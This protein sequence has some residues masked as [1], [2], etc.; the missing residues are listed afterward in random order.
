VTSLASVAQWTRHLIT[1]QAIGGS[2]PSRRTRMAG[3]AALLVVLC[4]GCNPDAASTHTTDL[5]AYRATHGIPPVVRV[6]QLDAK[7][8]ARAQIMAREGSI[9]HSSSAQ[10]TYGLPR[11][12]VQVAENIA[13]VGTIGRAIPALAGSPAHQAIMADPAYTQVGIGVVESGGRVFV[14]QVFV[15]R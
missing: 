15:A 8:V 12:W 14:A 9:S 1:D 6:R 2:S 4:V 11:G 13:E 3:I 10:L 5:N 7:A